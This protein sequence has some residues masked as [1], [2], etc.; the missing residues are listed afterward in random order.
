LTANNLCT[1]CGNEMQ[2]KATR[3][4]NCDEVKYQAELNGMKE[5]KEAVKKVAKSSP[6]EMIQNAK[7]KKRESREARLDSALAW[8]TAIASMESNNEEI[9]Y[10]DS[11]QSGNFCSN[12]GMKIN[13]KDIYCANCGTNLRSNSS[14]LS[15]RGSE[16]RSVNTRKPKSKMFRVVV[17]LFSALLGFMVISQVFNNSSP[18]IETEDNPIIAE[19]SPEGDWVSKC[20]W[21][22]IPNPNAPGRLKDQIESGISPTLLVQ[23]C[24]DVYVQP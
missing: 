1:T 22:T 19:P 6:M 17:L 13:F 23:R 5:S 18:G 12:C 8:G 21:I 11:G 15:D 9:I 3:C 20:R 2:K 7:N 16:S 24:T 4:L 10:E 14:N